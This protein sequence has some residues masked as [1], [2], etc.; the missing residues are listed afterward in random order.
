MDLPESR[1][2]SADG[3]IRVRRPI[4]AQ[5]PHDVLGFTGREPELAALDSLAADRGNAAVV[6]SA[7]DGIAG[8]GKTALAVHFA[9]R[10]AV[11]FPDG[12]L[13]VDLRGFDPVQLPLAPGDV[14]SGFLRGLGADHRSSPQILMSWRRCTGACQRPAGT[15]R[16]GQCSERRAGQTTAP[17]YGRLPCHS[18]QPQQAQRPSCPGR[19][20]A[21]HPGPAHAGCGRRADCTHSRNRAGSRRPCRRRQAGSVVRLVAAG[22]ADYGRPAA[23]HRHLT[24]TDLVEELALEHDRLNALSADEKTTQVRAVFSW[25]YQAL[26]PGPARA[27]RLLSLHPGLDISA[28]AAAA[29]L[30][31][32]VSETRQLLRT[33]TGGHLL[34]ETGRDRYRFHDL[35]RVYAAECAQ[36]S[37]IE[38]HRAAA[39]RRLLTWYLHTAAASSAPSTLTTSMFP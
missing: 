17:R 1:L 39:A 35:V 27:F 20:A 9:H 12:Q 29:L 21:S 15:H 34:E 11:A 4:P 36:V 26:P 10:V 25:S 13:F 33:L 22:T 16:S 24:M 14:L 6:I 38:S 3:A 28:S 5:L 8:I 31:A 7:I 30:D 2:I 32:A 19:R 23:T 18:H 37:E